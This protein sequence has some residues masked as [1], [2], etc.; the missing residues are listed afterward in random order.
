[1]KNYDFKLIYKKFSRKTYIT[2]IVLTAVVI[3][4]LSL[5]LLL[6]LSGFR[7]FAVNGWSAE[8]YHQ[9]GSLAI[10]YKVPFSELKVGDFVTWSRSGSGYVTHQIISIDEENQTVVTCQ[11]PAFDPET[12]NDGNIRYDQIQGKVLFT[13]PKLG[14]FM[15]GVKS[16][17]VSN[18][19]GFKLNIVGILFIMSLFVF[20]SSFKNFLQGNTMVFQGGTYGKKK[21]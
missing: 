5:L 18:T 14:F 17:I 3:F 21:K 19:I 13:I 9:Y 4:L 8:P 20:Y 10:D 7:T 16:L 6:Y 15:M 11:Q 12:N 2:K 1:M